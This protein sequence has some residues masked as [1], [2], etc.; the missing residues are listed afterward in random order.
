MR[1]K[2]RSGFTLV[3]LLVVIAIIGVLVSLLLPAVQSAREAARRMSCGNNTKQMSLGLHNYHD[4]FKEFPPEKIMPFQD[5][6][7]GRGLDANWFPGNRDAALECEPGGQIRWDSEPGNWEILMLPFIEQG[8]QYDKIDFNI[9]YNQGVN[10]QVFKTEYPAFI[11]P[12]NPWTNETIFGQ[13]GWDWSGQT[14]VIHYYACIGGRYRDENGPFNEFNFAG[15]VL[16]APTGYQNTECHRNTNGAFRQVSGT[17]ISQFVD[18]T[19]NTILLSEAWGYEPHHDRTNPGGPG[20]CEPLPP[21]QVNMSR[22]CDGRGS[23]I[24]A[25]AKFNVTNPN[26]KNGRQYAGRVDR[27][28]NAGSFHPGGL[29]LALADGSVRYVSDTID[30]RIYNDLATKDGSE[31]FEMP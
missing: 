24:S 20:K 6:L 7:K 31:A 17:R 16:P 21:G 30:N 23:R 10:A 13:P 4:S 25:L 18:G 22:I 11:C 15:P 27:W 12:S 28:F 14:S 1:H 29:H 19:S 3:E 5:G 9:R 8:A 2:S 26:A